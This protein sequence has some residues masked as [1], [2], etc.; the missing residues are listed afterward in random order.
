MCYYLK[1][2]FQGQRVKLTSDEALYV[3]LQC[4]IPPNSVKDGNSFLPLNTL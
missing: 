2:H 3:N 4:R 1:A